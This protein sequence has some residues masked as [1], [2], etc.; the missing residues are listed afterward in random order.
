MTLQEAQ[1]LKPGD[2][3]Y[4]RQYNCSFTFEKLI[5][6]YVDLTENRHDD[7]LLASEEGPIIKMNQASLKPPTQ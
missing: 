1:A 3:F 4:S 2:M 7:P 6:D 5:E